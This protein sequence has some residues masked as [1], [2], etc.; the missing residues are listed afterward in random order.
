MILLC[1]WN[2]NKKR[3][4]LLD[5]E[6]RLTVSEVVDG[7]GKTDKENQKVQTSSYKIN[8]SWRCNV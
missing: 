8:K 6:T 1:M 7:V 2:Q 5:T 3:N 4:K